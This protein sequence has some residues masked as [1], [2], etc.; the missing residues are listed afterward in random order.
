M[1]QP[2]IADFNKFEDITDFEI[3]LAISIS[4]AFITSHSIN[5]V[6]PSPSFAIALDK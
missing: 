4:L 3:F 6:A 2:K 1:S 5:F